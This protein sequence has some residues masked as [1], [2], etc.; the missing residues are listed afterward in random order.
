[1]TAKKLGVSSQLFF[2]K[3]GGIP[4]PLLAL[5]RKYLKFLNSNITGSLNEKCIRLEGQSN[6]LLA[7]DWLVKL[8]HLS[9]RYFPFVKRLNNFPIYKYLNTHLRVNHLRYFISH[10]VAF[11]FLHQC[12]SRIKGKPLATQVLDEHWVV[13]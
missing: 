3:L 11:Y 1:M 2:C 10:K 13:D 12:S 6:V 9:I 4:A 7:S 8:Q 5:V